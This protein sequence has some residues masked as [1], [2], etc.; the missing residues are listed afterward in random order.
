M[1]THDGESLGQVLDVTVFSF[2]RVNQLLIETDK[3][4]VNID[5]E[6]V[7]RVEADRILLKRGR[8]VNE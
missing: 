2:S 4:V 6:M 3:G 5:G 1:F 7:E 8:A